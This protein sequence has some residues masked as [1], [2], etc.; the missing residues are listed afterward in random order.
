[1]GEKLPFT[2]A[3]KV[4]TLLSQTL[5][6]F[7]LAFSPR[8]QFEF[9]LRISFPDPI[10]LSGSVLRDWN[11]LLEAAKAV[12]VFDLPDIAD[13]MDTLSSIVSCVTQI[14]SFNELRSR[15]RKKAPKLFDS[16]ADCN[17][18]FLSFVPWWLMLIT[19]P[20]WL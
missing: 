6:F 20:N 7:L 1:L 8:G 14:S 17:F 16:V 15:R 12:Q 11:G 9:R 13:S 19:C 2:L 5:D 18:Y 10:V 3:S 4:R